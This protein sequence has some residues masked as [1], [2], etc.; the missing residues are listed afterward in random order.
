MTDQH[1]PYAKLTDLQR[2]IA[3]RRSIEHRLRKSYD[4]TL[5]ILDGLQLGTA[6]LDKEGRV[7]FLSHVAQRLCGTQGDEALG[8]PW[9]ALLPFS[10]AD[11]ARLA[12][13]IRAGKFAQTT[14]TVRALMGREAHGFAD[15]AREHAGAFGAAA[16]ARS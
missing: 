9:T 13:K 15:F 5:S 6:V 3:E 10:D 16:P 1:I 12:A 11:R 4:D 14:D 8:M 2:E 7:T